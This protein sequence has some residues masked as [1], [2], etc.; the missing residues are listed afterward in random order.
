V[1]IEIELFWQLLRGKQRKQF[2]ETE[3][4]MKVQE[5]AAWSRLNLQEI[6][7]ITI[8]SIQS[9]L[10]ELVPPKCR[11]CFFPHMSGG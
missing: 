8:N 11:L 4:P 7:L 10:D 6:G 1:T 9:E 5:V 2:L 3:R